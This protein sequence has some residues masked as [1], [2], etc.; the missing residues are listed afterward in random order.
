[1][2]IKLDIDATPQELRTFFGLPDVEPLQQEMM[3]QL[4]KRMQEG[5][6]RYDPATLLKPLLPEHMR[7]LESLQESFWKSFFSKGES[8]APEAEPRKGGKKSD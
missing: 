1:M 4:R 3:E 7:T 5:M 6:E 8:D 2:K